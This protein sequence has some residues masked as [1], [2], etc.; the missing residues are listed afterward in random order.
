MLFISG[1]KKESPATPWRSLVFAGTY[2]GADVCSV[3]G[4]E[5]N[6][7][8]IIATDSTQISISNLYGVQKNFTG[9]VSSDT[10]I[11]QPQIFNTGNGNAQMQGSF[12]LISDTIYLSIIVATFGQRDI[13]NAV[14]VKH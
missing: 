9:V 4:T 3:S 6:T 14:L 13:C 2:A 7:I 12:V 11:I 8:S 10:C 1:C 5:A